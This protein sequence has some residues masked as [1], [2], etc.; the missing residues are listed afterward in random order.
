[1]FVV[2]VM[3]GEVFFVLFVVFIV[4]L[5]GELWVEVVEFDL[6]EGD[7][8]KMCFVVVEL[9]FVVKGVVEVMFV[10]GKFVEDDLVVVGW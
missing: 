6:C 4:G 10:E 7:E 9:G 8:V 2:G 3:D 5:G 1:M